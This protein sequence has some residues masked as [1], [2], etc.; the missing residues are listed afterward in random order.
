MSQKNPKNSNESEEEIVDIDYQ[1]EETENV[2]TPKTEN[3]KSSLSGSAEDITNRELLDELE[4]V[5]KQLEEKD[6]LF[7]KT[8]KRYLRALA[9]YEN[10]EKRTRTERARIVKQANERLLLK[11]VNLAESFEKAEVD[12]SNQEGVTLD[13][14]IEGFQA[15]RKQFNTILKNEGV[16]RIQAI[17]EKFDPNFHEVVYTKPNSDTEEDIILEEVQIGYLLNS[18]VLR[19]TKVVV[20]KNI[21]QGEN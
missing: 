2:T 14:V 13:S 5:Y 20:A 7:D 6:E 21:T 9:D 12:M 8:H 4:Q 18:K 17:G 1:I 15:V 10:L 19:P 16:E 3:K 11:L